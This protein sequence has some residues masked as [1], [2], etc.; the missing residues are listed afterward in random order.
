MP[1]KIIVPIKQMW[2][3]MLDS[4]ANLCIHNYEVR[5]ESI[6]FLLQ[7]PACVAY[8]IQWPCICFK[9]IFLALHEWFTLCLS[10]WMWAKVRDQRPIDHECYQCQTGIDKSEW[11][12]L[13]GLGSGLL[14]NTV[15][16]MFALEKIK[17]A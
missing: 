13:Q 10:L 11:C 3:G 12:V 7:K 5:I 1:L 6:K 17:F 15:Y 8:M 4:S 16:V 14:W 2:L 9:A